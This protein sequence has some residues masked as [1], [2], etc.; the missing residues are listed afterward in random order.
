MHC[1]R[2]ICR[3]K[4]LLIILVFLLRVVLYSGGAR[5]FGQ[6]GRKWSAGALRRSKYP[7]PQNDL[8]HGF[9][10]FSFGF[11]QLVEGYFAISPQQVFILKHV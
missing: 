5:D 1:G 8:S 4:F 3:L 9:L 6:R 11:P 2:K 7:E 10:D